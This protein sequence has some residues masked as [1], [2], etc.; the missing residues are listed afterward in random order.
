MSGRNR[1]CLL[2]GIFSR[3]RFHRSLAPGEHG[4][5]LW[6]PPI[7]AGERKQ[8]GSREPGRLRSITIRRGSTATMRRLGA[9]Y[10]PTR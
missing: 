6:R 7:G 8:G 5:P 3:L 9:L 2:V 4:R 1:T 10:W